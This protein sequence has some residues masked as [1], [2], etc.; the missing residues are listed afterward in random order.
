MVFFPFSM[1]KSFFQKMAG[2]IPASYPKSD[3]EAEHQGA[4]GNSKSDDHGLFRQ[5][6]LLK[7][8]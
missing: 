5:A 7:N 4:E 8:H 3:G 2:E 1:N 6:E